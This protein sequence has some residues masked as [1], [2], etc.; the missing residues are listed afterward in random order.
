MTHR[1][2]VVSNLGGWVWAARDIVNHR[3][4]LICSELAVPGWCIA[5][6]TAT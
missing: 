5:L 6:A 3:K 1:E 4:P 2:P